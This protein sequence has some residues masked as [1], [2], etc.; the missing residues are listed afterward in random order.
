MFVLSSGD[1]QPKSLTDALR[2][3]KRLKMDKEA[4]MK[5]QLM[6]EKKLSLQEKLIAKLKEKMPAPRNHQQAQRK[7]KS[8]KELC[9]F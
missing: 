5:E 8:F 6:A 1:T 2:V 9:K 7:K 3:I 4:M